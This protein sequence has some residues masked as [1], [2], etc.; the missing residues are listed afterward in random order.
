MDGF[1]ESSVVIKARLKT[2]PMQQWT[3]GREYRR[4]LLQAFRD[5]GIE[6]PP[7]S[8]QLGEP[9]KP[10]PVL[11]VQGAG[12]SQPGTAAMSAGR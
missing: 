11:L 2:L 1:K 7:R 3:V 5:Q 12:P 6:V 9:G 4:R 10:L 8:L